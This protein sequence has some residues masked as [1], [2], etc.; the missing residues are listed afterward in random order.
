MADGQ[1]RGAAGKATIGNQGAIFAQAFG[2]Q[3]AR[4]V[5]HFLHAGATFGAFVTNHQ[6]ITGLD[7]IAE[8]RIHR[9]VLTFENARRT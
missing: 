9:I 5:E 7:L 1:S 2:F 6:Y 4:G 3:V 8:N